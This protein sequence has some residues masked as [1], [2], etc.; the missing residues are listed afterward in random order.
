MLGNCSCFYFRL[1][2]FF[3]IKFL[4]IN[5]PG[6]PSECQT[7]WIQIKTD[8]LLVFIS[9]QNICK[10]LLADE[11][12]LRYHAK[13]YNRYNILSHIGSFQLGYTSRIYI[14]FVAFPWV[15]TSTGPGG[16]MICVFIIW[17]ELPKAQPKVCL[18][19]KPGIEPAPPGLQGI[20]LIHYTMGAFLS[21]TLN[22]YWH[23]MPFKQSKINL[24]RVKLESV[25]LSNAK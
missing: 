20:A 14:L 3:K 2:T 25:L 22:T 10:R 11:K 15:E 21:D 18:M 16:F 23:A 5:H 12:I 17:Q 7:V 1:L 9:V 4:Q 24:Q 6:P 13:S 8:I 19:E